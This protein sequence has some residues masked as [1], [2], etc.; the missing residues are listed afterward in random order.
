MSNFSAKDVSDA[1]DS[2]VKAGLT[3]DQIVSGAL[4]GALQIAAAGDLP[5]WQ[6]ADYAASAINRA[7]LN[8]AC[9]SDAKYPDQRRAS[10]VNVPPGSSARFAAGGVIREANWRAEA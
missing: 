3:A 10:F 9:A 4:S 1:L 5:A 2:L 7:G 8:A 6:A